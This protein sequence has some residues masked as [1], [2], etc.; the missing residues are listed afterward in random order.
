M[1]T[2]HLFRWSAPALVIG[3]VI[4]VVPAHAEEATPIAERARPSVLVE[5]DP[6]TFAFSGYAAHV[7]FSPH[8]GLTFGAGVYAMNMPKPI[9]ELGSGNEGFRLSLRNGIGL[10]VDHHFAR[11][12]H[13]WFVGLQL[14]LQR[15]R[16]GRDE[17]DTTT[18]YT[19]ALA[20]V[21]FG[22]LLHPFDNG[23]YVLPWIGVGASPRI[24]GSTTV[25][26]RRYSPLPVLAF[27][28][29]HVGWAF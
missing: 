7:R 16:V 26:D 17:T 14:A 4:A 28:A 13:G 18:D 22:T 5:T 19:T 8:G 1:L 23:F 15:W 27:G 10:F 25:D 24:S 2:S 29:V 12:P 11:R 21:R 20:M 6:A 3:Y 9:A